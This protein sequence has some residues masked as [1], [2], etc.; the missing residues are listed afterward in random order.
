[1]KT[2]TKKLLILLALYE[3][4]IIEKHGLLYTLIK[5]LVRITNISESSI[6]RLSGQNITEV[7]PELIHIHPLGCISCI[8]Y[9]SFLVILLVFFFYQKRKH[10]DYPKEQKLIREELV[11]LWLYAI[12]DVISIFAIFFGMLYLFDVE[13]YI[14]IQNYC[15]NSDLIINYNE[16]K[17]IIELFD[18]TFF[19]FIPIKLVKMDPFNTDKFLKLIYFLLFCVLIFFPLVEFLIE[20]YKKYRKKK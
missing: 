13:F 19:Y 14:F 3:V 20:L 11:L 10:L 6:I 5:N 18:I 1:M 8:A 15:S 9:S 2:T 7:P 17:V 12:I 16:A 4:L